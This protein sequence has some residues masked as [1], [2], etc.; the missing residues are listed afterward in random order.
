MLVWEIVKTQCPDAAPSL[1]FCQS[2][3]AQHR[4]KTINRGKDEIILHVSQARDCGRDLAYARGGDYLY[5]GALDP[6]PPRQCA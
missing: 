5:S 4:R 3:Q 2:L 6:R 1:P